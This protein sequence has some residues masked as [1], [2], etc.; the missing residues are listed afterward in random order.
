LRRTQKEDSCN[1]IVFIAELGIIVTRTQRFS[2]QMGKMST[3]C[4]S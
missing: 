2:K 3:S 4:R 1:E